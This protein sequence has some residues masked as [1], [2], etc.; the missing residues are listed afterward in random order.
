MRES[1]AGNEQRL[2]N[3][4]SCSGDTHRTVYTRGPNV[5]YHCPCYRTVTESA[6]ICVVCPV[7]LYLSDL[8]CTKPPIT[9]SFAC[10]GDLNERMKWSSEVGCRVVLYL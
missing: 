6:C 3:A 9:H 2:L 8:Q 5:L 7:K 10:Y 4:M 1:R